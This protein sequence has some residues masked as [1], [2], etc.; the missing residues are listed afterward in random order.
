M[1]RKMKAVAK[2][3]KG[4]GLEL[5]EVKI[6]DIGEDDV[7]IKVEATSICGTDVHIYNWDTWSKGRIKPLRVLGHEFAGRIVKVGKHTKSFKVGDYVSAE[8]HIVC[9]KCDTCMRN[10]SYVCLNTKIIGVDVDGSYAEF[11]SIPEEN[12]WKNDL[13]LPIEVA[14]IQEPL[15]NAVHTVFACDVPAQSVLLVG[16]GPIGL[17]G[18]GVAKAAGAKK[19]FA[20]DINPY[21]LNL[22]KKMNAD[23]VLNAKNNEVR[24]VI[25]RETEGVGVDVMLEMSGNNIA[26]RE[27]LKL[28]RAGGKV[29]LLGL[30][31]KDL[32]LNISDDV[33]MKGITLFGITG[34]K[35]FETWQQMHSLLSSGKLNV[36]PVITHRFKLEE[37]EQGFEAMNS[38]MSGKVVLYP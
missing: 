25:L 5:V 29:A 18:I 17:M 22:A 26:L 3:K 9:G 23:Y 8:S 13:K 31:P 35:I 1:K 30:F 21:R 38:G 37:F 20:V 34:R 12:I 28:V 14:S 36:K 11:I 7:L 15:G 27:N 16:C 19:V 4:K 33:V 10:Q 2:T 32:T 24:K 6:P